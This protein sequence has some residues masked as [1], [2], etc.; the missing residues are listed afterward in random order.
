MTGFSSDGNQVP[1]DEAVRFI[2]RVGVAAHGYGATAIRLELVLSELTRFFGLEGVFRSS[3]SEIIFAFRETPGAAQRVEI[4]PTFP[5]D[6]QLDKLARL[7]ELL[8]ELPESR[9]SL[10]EAFDRLDAIDRAPPPWGF[11]TLT[12]GY[13]S[14]ALGLTPLLG[15]SWSDTLMAAVLSLPVFTIVLASPRLGSLMAGLMPF[16]TALA[17]GVLAAL[18]KLWL[19]DLNP[20]LVVL[21]AVAVILPGYTISVG[22]GELVAQHVVSGTSNLTRGLVCLVKQVAGS[23]LGIVFV[24]SLATLPAGASPAPVDASWVLFMFPFFVLGLCLTF[25][26][27]GRD[28]LPAMLVSLLAYLGVF[29]GQA[30]FGSITGTL[31]GTVVA[32][33]TA[34]FWANKTGRPSTILLIPALVTLV[35]GTAGFRGLAELWQGD[36]MLGAEEILHMFVVA[37]TILAGLLIGNGLFRGDDAIARALKA[38]EPEIPPHDNETDARS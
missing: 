5:P 9:F 34:Q 12:L 18:A 15:G 13:I 1:Y 31:I 2:V 37:I 22:A 8:G 7:G 36:V 14:V 19:P 35:S 16:T 3:P 26:M 28:L 11:S 21:S 4:V 25:Q 6:V 10:A 24:S 27:A 29:G 30:L 20:V 17:A 32:V 23:G 38:R 33:G